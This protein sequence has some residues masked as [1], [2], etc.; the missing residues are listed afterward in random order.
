VEQTAGSGWQSAVH[1]DDIAEHAAKWRQSM[2]TGEPFENEARHRGA[3]GEYR[4][5]LVRAVP[6]RDEQGKILKWYGILT[7]IEDRKRAEQERERLR[8]LEADL[9][10]MNRVSMMGE[11]TAS[12]A[13]EIKQ[14]I[15]AG[16]INATAC[17]SWLRS[18][19]L[20]ISQACNAAEA[21]MSCLTRAAEIIDRVRALYGSG[22]RERELVDVNELVR[23]MTVMLGETATRN[24]FAARTEL[25]T[26]IQPTTADRVQLQ[27][28]LMNLMLNSIEAMQKT[29]GEL[30]VASKTIEDG[31]LLISVSD[32]GCGLPADQPESIFKP[33]FTTKAQG[34]GLGLSISRRIVE[35][36]GGRL[37][38][39]AKT[40]RGTIFQFTLPSKG[41]GD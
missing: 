21:T 28:V 36:H 19:R 20:D 32:T 35:S 27:Q 23:E 7:D 40:D 12:L 41:A 15:A 4:W 37:W 31:Q 8:Q 33:F 6:L 34:T 39:T 24:S 18:D 29:G 17:R 38:A 5:F 14:P 11:L 1:P 16:I 13:H 2:A 22:K 30:S 26:S 10:Q 9:V 3:E 25:E